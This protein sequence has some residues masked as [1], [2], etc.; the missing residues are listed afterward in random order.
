MKTT[1]A[2][3]SQQSRVSDDSLSHCTILPARIYDD[4]TLH[5]ALSSGLSDLR[6]KLICDGKNTR[7]ASIQHIRSGI[8]KFTDSVDSLK[9]SIDALYTRDNEA[10]DLLRKAMFFDE[11]SKVPQYFAQVTI[12]SA[13]HSKTLEQLFVKIAEREGLAVSRSLYADFAAMIKGDLVKVPGASI[14]IYENRARTLVKAKLV[15]IRQEY[16]QLIAPVLRTLSDLTRAGQ[17]LARYSLDGVNDRAQELAARA[18]QASRELSQANDL[19]DWRSLRRLC[20]DAATLS[21]DLS[22]NNGDQSEALYH[23]ALREITEQQLQ[24]ASQALAKEMDTRFERIRPDVERISDPK[25]MLA[26]MDFYLSQENLPSFEILGKRF[27]SATLAERQ[28]ALT[29]LDSVLTQHLLDCDAAKLSER[30]TRLRALLNRA[31]SIGPAEAL[32]EER[33]R[34]QEAPNNAIAAAELAPIARFVENEDLQHQIYRELS[35]NEL[36]AALIAV[37]VEEQISEIVGP[38][39][40]LD[41]LQENPQL[42]VDAITIPEQ[43]KEYLKTLST[44]TPVITATLSEGTYAPRHF[45]SAKALQNLIE[46]EGEELS[47]VPEHPEAHIARVIESAGVS[48]PR[49]TYAILKFGFLRGEEYP[50][51]A[52]IPESARYNRLYSGI[53][54]PIPSK[55]KIRAQEAQL[56][57][58]GIITFG[59]KRSAAINTS[60]GAPKELTTAL[61]MM[62][63]GEKATGALAV[64]V[65]Q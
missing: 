37:D 38:Q 39:I 28:K 40:A 18:S 41:L 15:T 4:S 48:S 57:Q 16:A 32:Q 12:L 53:A 44:V 13:I 20:A 24:A 42:L 26:A 49:L 43:F 45:C 7:L 62:Q 27:L 25:V 59:T 30:A 8:R 56:A 9:S 55:E 46:S 31:S 35:R 17:D 2:N 11:M 47:N 34:A 63:N 51:G 50:V 10:A 33:E 5:T 29:G 14:G 60:N 52:S 3:H 6:K 36:G 58:L 22:P 54:G 21:D 19:S 61:R 65:N 64:R 23:Q 1:T